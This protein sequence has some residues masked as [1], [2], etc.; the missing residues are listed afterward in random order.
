MSD[1]LAR[2]MPGTHF[3]CTQ[4]DEIR[5]NAAAAADDASPQPLRLSRS[6]SF[7]TKLEREK[8]LQLQR[9]QQAQAQAQGQGQGH[10][11]LARPTRTAEAGGAV[12]GVG[13]SGGGGGE[14]TRSATMGSIKM[15]RATPAE[16][17]QPTPR[18]SNDGSLFSVAAQEMEAVLSSAISMGIDDLQQHLLSIDC[19]SAR[20]GAL[21]CARLGYNQVEAGSWEGNEAD[22]LRRTVRLVVKCPPK[23][24][25]PDS[26]RVVINHRLARLPT[27]GLLLEREVSTLDVPYGDAFC[28]QERWLATPVDTGDDDDPAGVA[29]GGHAADDDD[30]GRQSCWLSVR[31]HVHF[32]SRV[33][34]MGSK[35]KHHST[36]KSRKVAALAV[37]L[38]AQAHAEPRAAIAAAAA[39][40]VIGAEHAAARTKP[41]GPAGTSRMSIAGGAN[42]FGVRNGRASIVGG[43]VMG[44]GLCADV[45]RP[46]AWATPEAEAYAA[47]HEKYAALLDEAQYYK[48]Q[49]QQLERENKRLLSMRNI[50][51][52]SKKELIEQVAELTETIKRERREKAAME[53]ALS[54][55][56]NEHIKALVA[57][58]QAQGG[59]PHGGGSVNDV[60]QTFSK[61]LLRR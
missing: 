33:N 39:A 35:I 58:L 28:L 3:S 40:A 30:A 24:M 29:V 5:R 36:K 42:A 13:S 19:D 25:L 55:A 26:T 18:G 51:G 27:G 14:L 7:G 57:Q 61:R 2:L 21:L 52:K 59:S 48:R 9:Q 44:G 34:M 45:T 46:E 56:Y 47:L 22:G 6:R 60:V 20:F 15:D 17:Q 54:E 32:K 10:G 31:C 43:G 4:A 38:L 11:Q 23:P 8:E 49:A 1:R 53:E 37:E 50:G 16:Q 41:G 12:N